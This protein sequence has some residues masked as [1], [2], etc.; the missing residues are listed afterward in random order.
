MAWV[1]YGKYIENLFTQAV[2][3][4]F[5][6]NSTTTVKI[7]LATS[8][9]SPNI[10]TD[11][12]WTA[13][14]N[15]EVTGSN[16]TTKGNSCDNKTVSSPSSGVVTV[17]ADDPAVWSQ[18]AAGF[19]DARYAIMFKD[20]GTSNNSPLVAYYDL[21]TNQGNVAGDLT[22]TLDAANGIFTAS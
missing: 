16:Y 11:Q 20:T 17:D 7:A 15:Y 14:S 2:P 19:S 1:V 6:D 8:S 5:D 4:D 10:D 13:G 9:Y 22:L 21:G 12:Y 18:D 3:V